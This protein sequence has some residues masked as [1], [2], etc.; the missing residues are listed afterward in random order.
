VDQE[1]DLSLRKVLTVIP[2]PL[3][4]DLEVHLKEANH[5]EVD[6]EADLSLRKVLAVI[7]PPLVVDLEVHL[8]AV[9]NPPKDAVGRNYDISMRYI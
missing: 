9:V 2:T 7:P 4:V 6:Q 5:L 8:E 3:V 1:A